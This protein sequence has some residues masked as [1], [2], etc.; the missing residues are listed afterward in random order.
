MGMRCA[1]AL[2]VAALAM[3]LPAPGL[4]ASQL[5][6]FEGA[7]PPVGVPSQLQPGGSMRL[8]VVFKDDHGRGKFTPRKLSAVRVD[9]MPLS[10]CT[11]Q[12]NQGT[13]GVLTASFPTQAGYRATG[14]KPGQAKPKRNRFSYS[15]TYA[16]TS[17]A[18][19]IGS[20]IYKIQ[21]RG[22]IRSFSTLS[23][24]RIDLD[25]GHQNCSSGGPR[26]ATGTQCRL[27]GESNPL[28]LCRI[29]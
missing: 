25:P 5:R 21:G 1:I 8:D 20:R 9:G 18:G 6:H 24:D 28:P 23:I 26:G 10:S 12:Q 14:R 7:L 19:T 3:A 13:A 27:T 4:A 16:F 29:D 11:N 22:A 2:G 15:T 17:F